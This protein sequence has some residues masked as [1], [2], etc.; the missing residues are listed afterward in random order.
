MIEFPRRVLRRCADTQLVVKSIL[1]SLV[2]TSDSE[3][4]GR[5]WSSDSQT[6]EGVYVSDLGLVA[7]I[8]KGCA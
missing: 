3:V 1:G 6:P 4:K 2:G 5:G 7:K 8:T